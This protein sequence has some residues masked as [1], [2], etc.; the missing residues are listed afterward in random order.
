MARRCCCDGLHFLRVT[1]KGLCSARKDQGRK[2]LRG[3]YSEA[4]PQAA[5]N[6]FRQS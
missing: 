1:R 4:F 2:D 3:Y 6:Q 5:R